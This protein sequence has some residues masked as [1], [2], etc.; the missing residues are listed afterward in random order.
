MSFVKS[1]FAVC[2]GII[3]TYLNIVPGETLVSGGDEIFSKDRNVLTPAVL[4][5]ASTWCIDCCILFLLA[6]WHLWRCAL[7]LRVLISFHNKYH[8]RRCDEHYLIIRISIIRETNLFKRI[9]ISLCK[10][11]K[12]WLVNIGFIDVAWY[13]SAVRV[14]RMVL[15]GCKQS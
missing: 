11:S 2:Y 13:Q 14:T 8:A 10:N 9:D 7:F 15:I 3:R 6:V 12:E 1:S 5:L 4:C